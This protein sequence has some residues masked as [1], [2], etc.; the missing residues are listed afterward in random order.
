VR[1]LV[2]VGAVLL[3]LQVLIAPPL[4]LA[5]PETPPDIVAMERA[6]S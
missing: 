5:A 1:R 4:L 2:Q 3:V 6:R